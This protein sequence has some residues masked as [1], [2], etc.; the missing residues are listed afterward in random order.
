MYVCNS[1]MTSDQ[2][3]TFDHMLGATRA[4]LQK[5][6]R[7]NKISLDDFN[8]AKRAL[9]AYGTLN[10]ENGVIVRIDDTGI[11]TGIT[12]ASD[13]APKT[14]MDPNGQDIR[15]TLNKSLFEQGGSVKLYGAILHEGSHGFDAEKWAATGFSDNKRPTKYDTEFTAFEQNIIWSKAN[16]GVSTSAQTGANNFFE[17]WN[18]NKS[19]S[20][21][22]QMR[23]TMI[24]SLYPNWP[25]KAFNKHTDGGGK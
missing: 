13:G 11:S 5:A 7:K 23:E 17:F 2:C 25:M 9:D 21:N 1:T 10:D 14:R 12:D 15:I 20:E 4:D 16:G 19:N 24:K 6:Y 8:A 3:E 22:L 18:S